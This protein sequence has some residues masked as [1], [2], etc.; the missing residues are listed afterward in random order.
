MD[1]IM[2]EQKV[3]FEKL[4]NIKDYW[5][6]NS[7]KKL[8]NKESRKLYECSEEYNILKTLLKSEEGR[9]AYE[10]IL[11]NIIEGVIHSIL[12]MIDGG[13]ELTDKFNIDIINADTKQSIKKDIALH[14]AFFAFLLDT[15]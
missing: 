1:I 8:R 4:V 13:D 7:I 9:R 10:E 2:N 3:L 5:V 14:E 6:N 15:E 12:V 11:N